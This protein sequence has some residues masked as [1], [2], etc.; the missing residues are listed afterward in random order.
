MHNS[1]MRFAI[2]APLILIMLSGCTVQKSYVQIE[3]KQFSDD[4]INVELPRFQNFSD[5]GF[6]KSLNDN[7]NR[8][9]GTWIENF[10][11][12][13]SKDE[14]CSFSLEQQIMRN[15]APV[16]SVVGEAY[17]YT[18]GVHGA[19][20]RIAE[21]IDVI[22]NEDLKL[23]ELFEDNSYEE[24]LNR[25]IQS[26]AEANPDQ[27]HD[28]WEKP[29]LSGINQEFFYLTDKELVVFYP[30]YELSYYAKGFVEFRIPY[31]DIVSYLKQEYKAL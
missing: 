17:V 28:L 8:S 1:L 24:A 21:N 27:Y 7:Y 19:K 20:S 25:Q 18:G 14:E 3:R 9:V 26:I 30:P 29:M 6:E 5:N 2:A 13:R 4:N 31:K 16:I 12:E 11:K 10:E 15:K 22:K 23:A